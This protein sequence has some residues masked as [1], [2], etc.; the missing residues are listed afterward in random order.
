MKKCY[1]T[2]KKIPAAVLGADLEMVLVCQELHALGRNERH[3][4]PRLRGVAITPPG[5]VRAV[6]VP[7]DALPGHT[8]H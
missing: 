6:T 5:Y 4:S 7:H 3:L 2:M 1:P 8:L